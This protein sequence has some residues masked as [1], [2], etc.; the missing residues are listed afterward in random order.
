MNG[1]G[2]STAALNPRQTGMAISA[3]PEPRSA[4]TAVRESPR[5]PRPEAGGAGGTGGTTGPNTGVGPG[6]G[7]DVGSPS[8]KDGGSEQK[9]KG[10]KARPSPSSLST[11][12]GQDVVDN[13]PAIAVLQDHFD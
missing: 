2:S 9:G 4:T 1:R 3:T 7:P 8:P 13:N 12:G 11:E 5:Q 6:A 10:G